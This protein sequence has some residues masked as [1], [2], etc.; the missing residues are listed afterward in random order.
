MQRWFIIDITSVI[1][2][3]IFTDQGNLNQ[4]A[5]FSR[6][7]RVYKI[8]R[9]TK[10]ARI[11][12]IVKVQNKMVKYLVEAMKITAG[13]ERIVCLIIIFFILQHCTACLW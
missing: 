2:F 12:K 5:R 11:I 10:L 6:I 8:I 4:L 7:G 3:D 13:F 1:P 9:M